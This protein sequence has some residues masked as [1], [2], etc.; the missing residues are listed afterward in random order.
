MNTELKI[1]CATYVEKDGGY[2]STFYRY[3]LAPNFEEA[4]T[5]AIAAH[6]T[7]WDEDTEISKDER[8]GYIVEDTFD[9]KTVEFERLE[10]TVSLPYPLSY[11]LPHGKRIRLVIED[12][13]AISQ[14]AGE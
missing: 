7:W 10:E 4:N 1:Y 11:T 2:E 5:Q 6:W 12:D 14:T 13:E 8:G 3:F 9:G